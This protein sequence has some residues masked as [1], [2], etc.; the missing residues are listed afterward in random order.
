L[1][2]TLDFSTYGQKKEASYGYPLIHNYTSKEYLVAENVNWA[3]TQDELGNMYFANKDGILKFDGNYWTKIGTNTE[4]KSISY[5]SISKT[6]YVGC[7]EDFGYLKVIDKGILAFV[8]LANKLKNNEKIGTVWDCF[9]TPEGLFFNTEN[10]LLRYKDGNFKNWKAENSFH[11]SFY[12]G[13]KIFVR[14]VGVGL[15]CLEGY[16]MLYIN[17]SDAFANQRVD[18]IEKTKNTENEYILASREKGLFK[19]KLI[20]ENEQYSMSLMPIN[21]GTENL[22][23]TNILYNGVKLSNNKLAFSTEAGGVLILDFEGN[24]IAQYNIDNGVNCNVIN[25][26]FEDINGNLWLATENGISLVMH[27]LP[28]YNFQYKGNISGMTEAIAKLDDVV[29]LGSSAGLFQFNKQKNQFEKSNFPFTQVWQLTELK[30]KKSLIAS[31]T[32]GIYKVTN[33]GFTLLT[34]AIENVYTVCESKIHKHVFYIGHLGGFAAY[35]IE[36]GSFNFVYSNPNI[37]YPIRSISEGQYGNIWLST[38]NDGLIYM[39]SGIIKALKQ[40]GESGESKDGMDMSLVH[41]NKATLLLEYASANNPIYIV[42]EKTQAAIENAI[43]YT[44]ET[45]KKIL[46]EIKGNKF[47]MG[48]YMGTTLQPFKKHEIQLVKGDVVYMFSDGYADQFGGPSAKK[49]KYNQFK[50]FILESMFLTMEEQ[51]IYLEQKINE[52]QGDLEQVDDVLVIGVRI[53]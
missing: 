27:S 18:F 33:T 22:F 49:L 31:T 39:R 46:F 34:S 53:V 2:L 6:V 52:W 29:Y 9:S 23:S 40:R 44:H 48:I 17:G 7:F 42:R 19:F 10:R 1:L 41:I 43:I 30:D 28:N 15:F 25:D 8:S 21:N 35:K 13:D 47:P 12:A 5:D 50:K 3:T 51:R 26:V 11:T 36:N 14:D 32:K 16:V 45:D 24:L 38:Q 37:N 4:A 20:N